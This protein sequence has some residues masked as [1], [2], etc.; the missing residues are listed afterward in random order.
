[1]A[2]HDAFAEALAAADKVVMAEIYAAREAN[3]H[4]ISADSIVARMKED[5]P[6]KAV[7]FCPS[8]EEIQDFVLQYAKEGDLV[9][10]M[11]AGD[12]RKVGDMILEKDRDVY[13]DEVGAHPGQGAQSRAVAD[14]E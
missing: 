13:L 10:V 11:G 5:D 9:I 14:V 4:Q 1:M 8:F 3:P 7:W 6:T 2:L 12:I